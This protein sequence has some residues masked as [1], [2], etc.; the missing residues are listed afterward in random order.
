MVG[1]LILLVELL[2]VIRSNILCLDVVIGLNNCFWV[3]VSVFFICIL[4][5]GLLVLL[6]VWFM[7]FWLRNLLKWIIDGCGDFL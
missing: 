4:K 1:W 5:F 7:F 2:L 6:I 3:K